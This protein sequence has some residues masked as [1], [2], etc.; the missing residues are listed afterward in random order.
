M[1]GHLRKLIS[2]TKRNLAELE[3][4]LECLVPPVTLREMLEDFPDDMLQIM[5]LPEHPTTIATVMAHLP[6]VRAGALMNRLPDKAV[7]EVAN[8]IVT[9]RAGDSGVQDVITR[10]LRN[11]W[12]AQSAS[13]ER[14]A[15]DGIDRLNAIL[16]QTDPARADSIRKEVGTK[17]PEMAAQLMKGS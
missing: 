14:A 9:M 6:G 17:H 7:A 4:Y 8:Q 15:D 3:E 5:I 16:A 2:K 1:K 13:Q 11:K 10:V 12:L